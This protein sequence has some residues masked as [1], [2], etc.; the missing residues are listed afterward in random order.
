M[1]KSNNFRKNLIHLRSKAGMSQEQLA[2]KLDVSRQSVSKWESGEAM[3]EMK[4]LTNLC[5]IFKVSL[6]DLVR[7]EVVNKEVPLRQEYEEAIHKYAK[8]TAASIFC[9]LFGLSFFSDLMLL[10][11]DEIDPDLADFGL[12]SAA[13]IF[14][15]CGI[16]MGWNGRRR[17]NLFRKRHKSLPPLYTDAEVN[18]AKKKSSLWLSI[19]TLA[20]VVSM[21]LAFCR[22]FVPDVE[23]ENIQDQ[24]VCQIIAI[25]VAAWTLII[26]LIRYAKVIDDSFDIERYNR[27]NSDPV[28]VLN[29]KLGLI[30]GIVSIIV[31]VGLF[32]PD[33]LDLDSNMIVLINGLTIVLPLLVG[34]IITMVLNYKYKQ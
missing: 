11:V 12:I 24:V 5:D 27:N 30:W 4:M 28:R 33:S 6:D 1:D 3:P 22:V 8:N 25:I 21:L 23:T 15:T 9:L 10:P 20:L 29:R 7:G 34:L 32:F 18:S 13:F 17:F 31:Y 2:G 16:L 26:P 14:F 19:G